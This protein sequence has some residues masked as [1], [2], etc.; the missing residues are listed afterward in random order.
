MPKLIAIEGLD[1]SGKGTQSLLLSESLEREGYRVRTMKARE[2]RLCGCTS[3][4]S[5]EKA[6][7]T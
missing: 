6:R 4:A 7:T 5:S 2:V 3:A 1:G